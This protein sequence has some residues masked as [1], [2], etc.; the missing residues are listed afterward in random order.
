M[1][2]GVGPPL[3][4]F[5]ENVFIS[6]DGQNINAR[7]LARELL[8]HPS[9]E[10][11][12]TTSVLANNITKVIRDLEKGEYRAANQRDFL[13][14]PALAL[15]ITERLAYRVNLPG[16]TSIM[17]RNFAC[18][19]FEPLITDM[20][21]GLGHLYTVYGSVVGNF[22]FRSQRQIGNKHKEV[23]APEES[24]KIFL[25]LIREIQNHEFFRMLKIQPD[26]VQ[27]VLE[28][29]FPFF[30]INYAQLYEFAQEMFVGGEKTIN[31]RG[32]TIG[33]LQHPLFKDKMADS[34]LG[35][36][37]SEVAIRLNTPM[38]KRSTTGLAREYEINF[39]HAVQIALELANNMNLPGYGKRTLKNFV[40]SCFN[41]SIADVKGGAVHLRQIF[42]GVVDEFQITPKA[43]IGIERA[44][45]FSPADSL[46]IFVAVVQKVQECDRFSTLRTN[47]VKIRKVL[48]NYFSF[49]AEESA[50]ALIEMG[51]EEEC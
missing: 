39:A 17:L 3:D 10:G 25:C 32:L 33:L 47:P 51:V 22:S 24:L 23:F 16:F 15:A 4:K 46:C 30:Q 34:V 48:E 1:L 7:E 6:R 14:D 31:L 40:S 11:K 42:N 37:I 41:P 38:R 28:T 5:I 27:N 21:G 12:I 35:K 45:I 49:T 26:K 43:Q 44:R 9:F 18:R 29:H 2:R 8:Y 50:Q 13:I 19:C 20:N 36:H